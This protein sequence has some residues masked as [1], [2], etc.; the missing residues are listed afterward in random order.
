MKLFSRTRR[1]AQ[2]CTQASSLDAAELH[3]AGLRDEL[4]RV[5]A[6]TDAL[7]MRRHHT[8]EQVRRL[9]EQAATGTLKDPNRLVTAL[10]EQRKLSIGTPD[11][12]LQA[13]HAEIAAAEEGVHAVRRKAAESAYL[14]AIAQYADAAANARLPELAAKVRA[15]APGAGVMLPRCISCGTDGMHSA[16]LNI[17]GALID[18]PMPTTDTL[19]EAH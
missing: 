11:E 12:R 17:G 1:T 5:Q 19:L 13:L 3:L 9:A 4:G 7:K 8:D 2:P 6:E 14:A 16:T 10:A 18:L 15:L